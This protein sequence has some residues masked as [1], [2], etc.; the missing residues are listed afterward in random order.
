MRVKVEGQVIG[1][2]FPSLIGRLKRNEKMGES[3]HV[4]KFPSLIGR[5]K[6]EEKGHLIT[7]L[8]NMFPS[9]IGRLKSLI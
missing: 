8:Q 5:L 7:Q 4:E 2:R 6:R 3:F 1:M 9:L